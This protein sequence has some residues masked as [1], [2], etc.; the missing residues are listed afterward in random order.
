MDIKKEQ[1]EK[2]NLEVKEKL[3]L[4]DKEYETSKE[5]LTRL[6]EMD[7]E[8]NPE[9]YETNQEKVKIKQKIK[10]KLKN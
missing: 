8:Q 7:L 1:I 2:M 5:V 9:L 6:N 3:N 4:T 10:R